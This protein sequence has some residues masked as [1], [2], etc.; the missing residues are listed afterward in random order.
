MFLDMFFWGKGAGEMCLGE[1]M[2]RNLMPASDITQISHEVG[3][4]EEM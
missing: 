2:L 4:D 1:S 3:I